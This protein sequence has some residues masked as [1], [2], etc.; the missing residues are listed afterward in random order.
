MVSSSAFLAA[1]LLL[2]AGASGRPLDARTATTI[3]SSYAPT[4]G[5]C[6]S[7]SL[8][9][10]GT[11]ISQAETYFVDR[12]KR[13]V[14]DKWLAYLKANDVAPGTSTPPRIAVAV[15]GGGYR[16]MINGA[17][18][19]STLDSR[20]PNSTYGGVLGLTHYLSGLSGGSW[21]LGSLYTSGFPAIT[22]QLFDNNWDFEKD[23]VSVLGDSA[24]VA[25]FQADVE[26]KAMAGYPVTM[27]DF[28]SLILAKHLP[29]NVKTNGNTGVSATWSS[30]ADSSAITQ[31]QLPLPIVISTQLD[32]GTWEPT[33]AANVWETTPF[34]TGSFLP[35]VASFIQTKYLGTSLNNTIATS[36]TT[37]FDQTSII[38]GTS[39]A[40]F[41]MEPLGPPL[42]GLNR[43]VYPNMFAGM[44][45]VE[46]SIAAAS[47][48]EFADGGETG[49]NIP[50]FP[51]LQKARAVDLILAVDGGDDHLDGLTGSGSFPDGTSLII[52][53]QYMGWKGYGKE[54]FPPIPNS[55]NAF[56]KQRLNKRISLFGCG[57]VG[58]N[59]S[60]DASYNGPMIMYIPNR[61]VTYNT[62]EATATTVQSAA[63]IRGFFDN[64]VAYMEEPTGSPEPDHKRCMACAL[65]APSFRAGT[66]TPSEPCKRCLAAW[67]WDGS[68]KGETGQVG[69]L[70]TIGYN[71]TGPAPI[72]W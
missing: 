46:P 29:P 54:S 10:T 32:A 18:V 41:N 16:A 2:A 49:Q 58:P 12:R 37:S 17:A 30:I 6:P 13:V 72:A 22:A 38:L 57:K 65:L 59:G 62:G 53:R 28:W 27:I 5:T 34:E 20:V 47:T 64:A 23:L 61:N 69:A 26:A 9:R 40:L 70:H 14:K 35:S 43:T 44:K 48:L 39:S 68:T 15:S 8:I 3:S 24:A 4:R 66:A 33:V 55:V 31:A 52:T 21:L 63:D 7:G 45:K 36:C 42:P 51:L 50:L 71:G 25:A 19:L 11:G 67:C 60:G 1:S 56:V